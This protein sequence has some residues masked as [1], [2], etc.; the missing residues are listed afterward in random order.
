MR[1]GVFDSG[2]GGLT[3]LKAL[4]EVLPGHDLVYLGDTARIPYGTRSPLTVVRYSLAVASWLVS[5]AKVERIIVACNTATTHALPDLRRVLA[6][7]GVP[8][9]GVVEPGVAAARAVHR[10]GD[11]AILGTQGTILG[12]AYHRALADLQPAVTLHGVACPLF[13]PLVEEGWLTGTVPHDVAETYVGHLR[14]RVD[15]AILGC[16]HYP[17]LRPVLS[18]VLPGTVLIDSA[19]AM[20]HAT[21]AAVGPGVG[22][23]SRSY[24]VTDNIERFCDV[25]AIFLGSRPEGVHWVDLSP[26]PPSFLEGLPS[27]AD[28]P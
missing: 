25:G 16:T 17:L 19:D 28:V 5:E 22:R 20:A 27:P 2:I 9:D 18:E 13:V 15:T 10:G 7:L 21:L 24:Y 12:G 4:A 6:P 1:I 3:V 8:V 23:G 14:G 26:A 11:L